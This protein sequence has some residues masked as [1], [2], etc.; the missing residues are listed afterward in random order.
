[1]LFTEC[2]VDTTA[3]R[4]PR[5]PQRRQDAGVS[6]NLLLSRL[7]K[8]DRDNL[9][10]NSET[11]RLRLSTPIYES[12]KEMSHAYFPLSGM[13]S[14]VLD[15]HGGGTIEV[16]LIGNEG[17]VGTSIANGSD[18]SHLRALVQFD[19]EFVEIS[20]AKFREQ[21]A[22]SAPLTDL[23]RRFSETLT[24]QISQSVMCNRL[25]PL[26]ERVCRWLCMAHDRVVSGGNDGAGDMHLTQEFLSEMLGIRRPS[27]TVAA[28]ML[29]KAGLIATK[30]GALMVLN[31]EGLQQGSCECYQ[32]VTAAY[33]TIMAATPAL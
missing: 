13:I 6:S 2:E 4:E 16:G 3:G 29:Q 33:A 23:V 14:L 21:L 7:P 11:R 28:G 1:M 17:I 25:H 10:R 15:S 30:R 26:E 31:R 19:G 9:L 24:I 18:Q 27:V 12:G 8:A 22:H 32:I 20:A 5:P